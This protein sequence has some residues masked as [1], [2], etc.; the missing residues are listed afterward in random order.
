VIPAV[1]A[2]FSKE[3]LPSF[4]RNASRFGDF[5][6]SDDLGISNSKDMELEP[7]RA[8]LCPRPFP[9]QGGW[10]NGSVVLGVRVLVTGRLRCHAIDLR[11]TLP[12]A[13]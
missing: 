10:Q 9:N 2:G 13:L 1:Y 4:V 5:S 8:G 12:D 3:H 11:T 7:A 6:V